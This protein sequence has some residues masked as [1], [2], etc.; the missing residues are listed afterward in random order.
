MKSL[1]EKIKNLLITIKADEWIR[2]LDWYIIK[3]WILSR[4]QQIECICIGWHGRHSD[5]FGN[6]VQYPDFICL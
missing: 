4:N 1:K 6:Y 2:K 3:K 5:K